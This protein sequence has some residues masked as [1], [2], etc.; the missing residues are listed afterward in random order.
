MA[1]LSFLAG[2]AV[3]YVLGAKAG[4]QRYEQIKQVSAKAW[5]SQPVQTQVESAKEVAKT[6]VAPVAAD[7]VA[8]AARTTGEKLRHAKTIPSTL[9]DKVSGDDDPGD[10]GTREAVGETQAG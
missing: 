8:D 3:G 6:K 5:Q 1:K 4:K 9:S 10:D 2:M 7:M